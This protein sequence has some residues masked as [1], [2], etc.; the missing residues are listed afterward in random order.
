MTML[1]VETKAWSDEVAV[2]TRLAAGVSVS[3]TLKGRSEVGVFSSTLWSA[4][5]EMVGASFW[6]ITVTLKLRLTVLFSDCPSLTVTVMTA[7]PVAFVAERRSSVP[8]EFG[9]A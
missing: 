2:T 8:D 6:P 1:F 7:V 5:L 3:P 9:L 4:M